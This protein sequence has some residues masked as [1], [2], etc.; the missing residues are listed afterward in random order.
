MTLNEYQEKALTTALP[1]ARDSLAYSI[2]QC[3][4]E[5]GEALSHYS[6]WIRG[7]CEAFPKEAIIKELGDQLWHIALAAKQL[8][9][10]LEDLAQINLNKLQQRY[11]NNT[12]RGNG[13]DR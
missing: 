3:G 1:K 2:M 7:D 8:G 12:L 11:K 10:S 6:K 5:A 9:Y 13:D 4:A